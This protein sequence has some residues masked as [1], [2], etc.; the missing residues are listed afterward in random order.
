[1]QTLS[2]PLHYTI[3]RRIIAPSRT[4][5]RSAAGRETRRLYERPIYE[6]TIQSTMVIQEDAEAFYGF[7]Q[8][9]QG[10]IAFLFNAGPWTAPST[11]LLFGFGDGVTTE[12]YIN[13]R[14]ITTGTIQTYQDAVLDSPTPGIDLEAGL[15]TYAT[16]PVDQA[17]LT[18][19]YTCL[20]PCV[21]SNNQEVLLN[22]ELFYA[23][24][25]RYQ[26]IV[27]REF[28]L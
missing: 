19:Q 23:T 24:L 21:F 17:R 22:E 10:D 28:I 20:Y 2:L 13:N 1:M 3:L 5:I 14:H 12:F 18:A 15:L 16:A 8:Y 7:V 11:P 26:G 6:F 4:G 27:L 9:H 25:F